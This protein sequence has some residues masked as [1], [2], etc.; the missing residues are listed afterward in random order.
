[1]AGG[2]HDWRTV[3]ESLC[4]D[5][6]LQ[7]QHCRR[8]DAGRKTTTDLRTGARRTIKTYPDPLPT[9]CPDI[10]DF[11]PTAAQETDAAG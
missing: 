3:I 1:M 4:E 6:L 5:G 10:D 9:R 11:T 2:P 7:V 8:C